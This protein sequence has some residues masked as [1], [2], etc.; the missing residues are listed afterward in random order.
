MESP[1]PVEIL[2][3]DVPDTVLHKNLHNLHNIG[4]RN[5]SLE[6]AREQFINAICHVDNG[7]VKHIA[8]A[9][10]PGQAKQIIATETGVSRIINEVGLDYES[11]AKLEADLSS[12]HEPVLGDNH[13]SSIEN[14]AKDSSEIDVKKISDLR[15]ETEISYVNLDSK[16]DQDIIKNQSCQINSNESQLQESCWS[17]TENII[18]DKPD[19]REIASGKE[20]I[21][22]ELSPSKNYMSI[23]HGQLDFSAALRTIDISIT[24]PISESQIIDE[25]DSDQVNFK[26]GQTTLKENPILTTESIAKEKVDISDRTINFKEDLINVEL[27]LR[28]DSD[29]AKV[30]PDH[31]SYSVITLNKGWFTAG[32]VT[33]VKTEPYEKDINITEQVELDKINTDYIWQDKFSSQEAVKD[34][35]KIDDKGISIKQGANDIELDKAKYLEVKAMSS[36]DISMAS[37]DGRHEC[38]LSDFSVDK[39]DYRLSQYGFS[40]REEDDEEKEKFAYMIESNLIDSA[41]DQI[42]FSSGDVVDFAKFDTI[43]DKKDNFQLYNDQVL[44]N[45]MIHKGYDKEYENSM[46]KEY[47]DDVKSSKELL[48]SKFTT[49]SLETERRDMLEIEDKE[50]IQEPSRTVQEVDKV[51]KV[52]KE[53]DTYS[54]DRGTLHDP[55]LEIDGKYLKSI[56]NLRKSPR[57]IKEDQINDVAVKEHD[58]IMSDQQAFQ[59]DNLQTF[60]KSDMKTQSLDETS[61][62]DRIFNDQD[63]SIKDRELSQSEETSR[64]S[65]RTSSIKTKDSK[66]VKE[67]RTRHKSRK[68][69]NYNRST[70]DCVTSQSKK[71]LQNSSKKSPAKGSLKKTRET[72]S[73]KSDSELRDENRRADNREISRFK[74]LSQYPSKMSSVKNPKKVQ[75]EEDIKANDNKS[76]DGTPRYDLIKDVY[77]RKVRRYNVPLKGSLDSMIVSNESASTTQKPKKDDAFS[78]K[79]KS[80][81]SI[82][83][84]QEVFLGIPSKA[85]SGSQL[86]SEQDIPD[87]FCSI[88]CYMNEIT[89]KTEEEVSSPNQEIF[90]T[91]RSN[92]SSV[93]DEDSTECDICGSLNLQDSMD[94]F[95]GKVLVDPTQEEIPCELCRI[96]GEMDGFDQ[97]SVMPVDKYTL[98]VVDPDQYDDDNFEIENCG[99]QSVT[100][101]ADDR[102]RFSSQE[103]IK[104]SRKPSLPQSSFTHGSSMSREHPRELYFIPK[105]EI[106]ILASG[107]KKASRKGSLF[108]K[109]ENLSGNNQDKRRYS[110]IDNLQLAK[111]SLGIDDK[112]FK[113]KDSTLVGSADNLRMSINSKR[114]KSLQR[115]TDN[116]GCFDPFIDNSNSLTEH[117]I[118]EK[119]S[120]AIDQT[121]KSNIRDNE[122]VKMILTQHGIKVL[123]EKETAL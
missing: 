95:D 28:N 45:V 123:S 106:A 73:R 40:D 7:N 90:Y 99:F 53:L 78:K 119:N 120:E 81:E 110:S 74:E 54:L 88:C 6:E 38:A 44:G 57:K 36:S 62:D 43:N 107:S 77:T 72:H 89:F 15:S 19:D 10:Y 97:E 25:I 98:K 3:I 30:Q 117:L 11:I 108:R 83:R 79:S 26:L 63:R 48:Q 34:N 87:E 14:I 65:S 75:S 116:I 39:E 4:G 5:S 76:T 16:C 111:L 68:V 102:S 32:E 8:K 113:V 82:K 103:N 18:S 104:I 1:S 59:P 47:D 23:E 33:D 20:T 22:I 91:L 56:V 2:S 37:L 93:A 115:S 52:K 61:E 69:K 96:C 41:D 12:S 46:V 27:H 121:E 80:Y 42:Y 100:E 67:D 84:I 17:T 101:L 85:N 109:K 118:E 24:E 60:S 92:C 94:G 70:D 31:S 21:K 9:A 64:K 35:T 58:R 112:A 86:V 51:D 122:E 49:L 29:I 66:R 71:V 55:T 13:S 114:S 105:D 50:I